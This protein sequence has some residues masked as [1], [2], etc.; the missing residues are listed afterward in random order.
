MLDREQIIVA[1]AAWSF[2]IQQ[3]LR[4][5]TP[6]KSFRD[7]AREYIKFSDVSDYNFEAAG[8]WF[9]WDEINSVLRK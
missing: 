3:Y 9:N 1:V 8:D 2:A 4:N 6:E 5:P 7:I